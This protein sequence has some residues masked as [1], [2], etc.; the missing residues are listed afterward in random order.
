MILPVDGTG[1]TVGV[2]LGF[3]MEEGGTESSCRTV[4]VPNKWNHVAT[5]SIYAVCV[6]VIVWSTVFAS[7]PWVLGQC[8]YTMNSLPDTINDFMPE[9]IAF[10]S[11][12]D[13]EEPSDLLDSIH[14]DAFIFLGDNIYADTSSR[15]IMT[16]LYNRLSCKPSFQSL[17]S[18]IKY[19][20]SIWDDHD[21]GVNDAGAEYG[22][23][24]VSQQI[25][26]DFWRVPDDSER[27]RKDGGVYGSYRFSDGR[28]SVLI[29]MLDLRY[30]R[31]SLKV[32][33]R[34]QG[35]YCSADN[36]TM[37]GDAQWAWLERTLRANEDV[38]LV[39]I[40]SSTQFGAQ[41]YGY[42]TWRN[43]PHE[44]ARL[45]LLLNPNRTVFLTG[46]VHWGEISLT[47][48]GF[49]DITSSGI[50]QLDSNVIE[51]DKRVG[52]PVVEFNYGV[53]NLRSMRATIVGLNTTVSLDLKTVRS[54]FG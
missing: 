41:S 45:M 12:L 5:V 34:A 23:K 22:M 50:S 52:P 44:Q 13:N 32:C 36:G 24:D 30:F 6:V 31:D 25:F 11:C 29:V 42:E 8:A 21:Y 18:R 7:V 47:E 49:Y 35:W 46:D 17:V 37:L 16:W 14:A 20:M 3:L 27:R 28:A 43:L 19:T 53:L 15:Y 40:A 48:D 54:P 39:I 4:R 10:G 9:T 2:Y 38:G 51:N 33:K 1:G 26:L